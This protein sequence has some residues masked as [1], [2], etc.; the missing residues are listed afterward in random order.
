MPKEVVVRRERGKP[1]TAA[2]LARIERDGLPEG[3]ERLTVKDSEVKGL[4]L[5][6]SAKG[7][8]SWAVSKR[9]AGQQRR[10]TLPHSSR[11]SLAEARRA[12]IALLDEVHRGRDPIR[13][14]REARQKAKLARLG[15]GVAWSLAALIEE[16]GAKVAKPAGQRSWEIRREHLRREYRA[17]LDLPAAEMTE[18]MIWSVLDEATARGARVSGLRGLTYLRAVLRWAVQ[19]RLI[20]HDP[21]EAMPVRDIRKAMAHKPRARVLSAA[22]LAK[23]WPVLEADPGPYAAVMR[24]ALLTGQRRD[25]LAGMRWRD[26]DLARAEWHQPT[27][28]ADRPHLVPLS[29][30]ARAIVEAQPRQ[31]ELVFINRAGGTIAGP[32]GN[33]Q[34]ALASFR[35]A[36]G[37]TGWHVHDLRRTCATLLAGLKVDRGVIELLL[38]HAETG[39]RGGIVAATYNRHSY[40]AEKREAV[41]HLARHIQGLADGAPGEGIEMQSR[42]RE[43]SG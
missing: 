24:L 19:R 20:E 32:A 39:A 10:F 3:V 30:A 14:R 31:G 16:Y 5:R 4:E 1:L 17:L 40:A 29:A 9:V 27:N 38:N 37:V 35:K 34:R 33:W 25:E 13:E 42:R 26:L 6:L 15:I 41:E 7:G 22:E 36:S 23:L 18:A 21:T 28:K 12:A 43:P 11:L 2:E 8:R